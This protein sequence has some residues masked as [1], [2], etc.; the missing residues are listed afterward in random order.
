MPAPIPLP[1]DVY[2][3][4]DGRWCR[5]CP[6]CGSEIDHLRRN[7]CVNA[8]LN[9]QP[10]KRCSNV[11]NHPSGM[12]GSVRLSW[13]TAFMKSGIMRGY[14]WSITPEFVDAIYQEQKGRCSYSGLQIGWSVSGWDHT[15]SIDRIDNE[16]GYTEDNVHLVHKDVNMMRGTLNNDSFLEL[17]TLISENK[18]KW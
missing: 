6:S 15:A 18:V 14:E 1:N 2:K 11:K 8:S 3:R 17:C 12:V 13:Y 7:Y 16:R 5:S 4:V 9:E 10:C